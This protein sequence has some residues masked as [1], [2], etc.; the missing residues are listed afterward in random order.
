MGGKIMKNEILTALIN[1]K[2]NEVKLISDGWQEWLNDDSWVIMFKVNGHNVYRIILYSDSL[3]FQCVNYAFYVSGEEY[4]DDAI[5]YKSVHTT[6]S[7][8]WFKLN[9]PAVVDGDMLID[10]DISFWPAYVVD[11]VD[12]C[13]RDNPN[14]TEYENK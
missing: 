2:N 8:E 11:W 12:E 10:D 5:D 13:E 14:Y 1:H 7:Y 9:H 3:Y 4:Y 6:Q